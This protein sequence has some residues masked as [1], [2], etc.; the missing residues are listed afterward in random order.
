LRRGR[1][2]AVSHLNY[3]ID[4]YIYVSFRGEGGKEGGRVVLVF[5]E[6]ITDLIFE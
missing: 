5:R 4:Y 1:N 3:S 2:C 6:N